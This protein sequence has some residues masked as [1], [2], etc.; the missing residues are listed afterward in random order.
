MQKLPKLKC[1]KNEKCSIHIIEIPERGE[2]EHTAEEIELRM[3]KFP[4]LIKDTVNNR[5]RKL[6][7]HQQG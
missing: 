1:K 7:E 5:S 4:T 3:S 6:R 2:R